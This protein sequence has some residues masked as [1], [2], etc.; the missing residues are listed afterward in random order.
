MDANSSWLAA[1]HLTCKLEYLPH[2]ER[3]HLWPYPTS[4][5]FVQL[6]A[7]SVFVSEQLVQTKTHQSQCQDQGYTHKNHDCVTNHVQVLQHN[8]EVFMFHCLSKCVLVHVLSSSSSDCYTV[9]IKQEGVGFKEWDTKRRVIAVVSNHWTGLMDWITGLNLFISH[10]LHP[11]KCHKFDCSKHSSSFHCM[12]G[13]VH[14]CL[15]MASLLKTMYCRSVME[16]A[17]VKC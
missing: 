3:Y 10:D 6:W 14:E 8:T 16:N 2:V 4:D 5:T 7:E 17:N 1:S 13:N 12:L 15:T 11:I 9:V